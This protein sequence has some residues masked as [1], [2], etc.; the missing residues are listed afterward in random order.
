MSVKRFIGMSFHRN[1]IGGHGA[2]VTIFEDKENGKMV[3]TTLLPDMD[4][5]LTPRNPDDPT[6]WAEQW[7]S[8]FAENTVVLTVE[9][10]A[11]GDV[12]TGWRGADTWGRDIAREWRRRNVDNEVYQSEA[13]GYDPAMEWYEDK[14]FDPAERARLEA[15]NTRRVEESFGL[16]PGALG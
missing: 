13:G 16:R 1:G 12:A 3:A 9:Q 7:V 10:I 14:H 8:I 5:S 15:E 2:L 11:A 6:A 4:E